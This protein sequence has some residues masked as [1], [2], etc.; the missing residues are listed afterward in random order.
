MSAP[1]IKIF[2]MGEKPSVEDLNAVFGALAGKFGSL[3]GTDFFWPLP[4]A[5]DLDL[6]GN[7][8]LRAREIF[9]NL[10]MEEYGSDETAFEAAINELTTGG[11]I[12]IPRNTTITLSRAI[13]IRSNRNRVNVI[14]SGHSSV[15]R[16]ADGGDD[17]IF[18][19]D[20]AGRFRLSGF[21]LDGNKGNNTVGHGIRVKNAEDFEI[22]NLWIGGTVSAPG[23][24]GTAAAAIQIE[25][26]AQFSVKR[27][28]I[29]DCVGGGIILR[30]SDDFTVSENTIRDISESGDLPSDEKG[31]GIA[32]FRCSNGR[33]YGNGIRDV[34]DDGISMEACSS[35]RAS[36]NSVSS[37]ANGVVVSG[38][39]EDDPSYGIFITGNSVRDCDVGLV[40]GGNVF[41]QAV[42]NNLRLNVAPITYDKSSVFGLSNNLVMDIASHSTQTMA[43]GTLRTNIN[44]GVSHLPIQGIQATWKHSGDALFLKNSVLGA[45]YEVEGPGI[46]TVYNSS[47]LGTSVDF[48]LSIFV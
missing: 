6:E 16:M 43:S 29:R 36:A 3:D 32:G 25:N 7:R 9:G 37:G 10:N 35:M 27:N 13:K 38:V 17:S 18:S 21:M 46:V 34:D 45:V 44:I 30:N 48:Y 26:C 4:L 33:I 5:G 20:G 28:W 23:D 24:A 31:T 14:G 40:V 47:S 42:A 8:L 39:S 2:V 1:S 15:I 41:G 11:L 22:S 12:F 19:I